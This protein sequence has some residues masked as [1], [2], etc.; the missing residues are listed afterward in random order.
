[1][2]RRHRFLTVKDMSW[3]KFNIAVFGLKPGVGQQD[4]ESDES[5]KKR[6]EDE[7]K[8]ELQKVACCFLLRTIVAGVAAP[9]H[10]SI[11]SETVGDTPPAC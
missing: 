7:K 8:E 9:A 1:M 3:W 5:F 10:E 2:A 4:K 11:E 6:I